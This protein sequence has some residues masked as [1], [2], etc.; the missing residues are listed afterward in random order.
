MVKLERCPFCGSDLVEFTPDEEQQIEDTTTGFIWCHGCG[1]S[2]DSFYN[3]KIAAEKWNR[4]AKSENDPKTFYDEI[5][6]MNIVEMANLLSGAFYGD[7]YEDGDYAPDI[8]E[9]LKSPARKVLHG[10]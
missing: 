6:S 2:S 4:R 9:A 8:M 5:K 3:E 1:F 7:G 10:E